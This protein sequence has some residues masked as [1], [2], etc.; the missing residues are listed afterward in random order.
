[1]QP[2]PAQQTFIDHINT[3]CNIQLPTE[4]CGGV[5]DANIIA[6]QGVATLDEW[7]PYGDGDHTVHERASKKSFQERIKLVSEIF[8]HFL[9][10][11]I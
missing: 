1:M 9:E 8:E 6:S 10:G 11:K 3:L 4:K 2:S 5:S 7:G